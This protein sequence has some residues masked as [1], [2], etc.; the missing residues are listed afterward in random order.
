M[1][2]RR[3]WRACRLRVLS[4][5]LMPPD[6][7][8]MPGTA[9]GMVRCIVRTV[10]LAT[11]EGAGVG[12]SRPVQF[13]DAHILT[14]IASTGEAH[15]DSLQLDPRIAGQGIRDFISGGYDYRRE[16]IHRRQPNQTSQSTCPLLLY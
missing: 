10:Y 13:R 12:T 16:A 8:W 9:G 4:S 3:T 14:C 5:S 6:R 11:S 15:I 7:K 1:Q 2:G